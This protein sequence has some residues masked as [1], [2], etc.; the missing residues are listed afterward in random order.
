MTAAG[1]QQAERLP[2]EEIERI[3]QRVAE[4]LNDYIPAS[5]TRLLRKLGKAIE[6]AVEAWHRRLL[7]ISGEDP[8]VLG[9]L[10]GRALL[11]Y[12]RVYRRV[13]GKEGLKALYIFHDEF[14]DA[15]IRKEVVKGSPLPLGNDRPDHS[16][17]RGE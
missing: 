11:Y 13:K 3:A 16:E 14:D 12:E 4:N 6:R 2:R 1:E 17:V 7:V 8:V 5:F 9:A 10:A 15:R